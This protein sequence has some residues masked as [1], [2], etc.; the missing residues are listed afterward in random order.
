MKAGMLGT[1]VGR[2]GH[3]TRF[4]LVHYFLLLL[5]LSFFFLVDCRKFKLGA[6]C[7]P[8]KPQPQQRCMAQDGHGFCVHGDCRAGQTPV[9]LC[10]IYIYIYIYLRRVYAMTNLCAACDDCTTLDYWLVYLV[11]DTWG[12]VSGLRKGT[13]LDDA[14]TAARKQGKL[15]GESTFSTKT[16]TRCPSDAINC[17]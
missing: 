11:S 3:I 15:V 2:L 6:N 10:R 1:R 12:L 13:K 4:V 14:I 9:Y 16:S 8:C 17:E 7:A 5:L